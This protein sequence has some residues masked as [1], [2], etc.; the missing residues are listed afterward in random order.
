M[1]R[2]RILILLAVP[3]LVAGFRLWFMYRERQSAIECITTWARLAPFPDSIENL[4][5]KTTGN[6]FTRGFQAEF[7]LPPND[8]KQWLEACPGIQGVEPTSLGPVRKHY[9]IDPGGGAQHAEMEVDE[10][11]HTVTIYVQW[12]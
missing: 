6:M 2:R 12:S 8:L 4:E 11:G 7:S 5:I 1:R 3:L 9:D 10:H